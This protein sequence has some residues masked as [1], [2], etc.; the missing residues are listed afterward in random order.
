MASIVHDQESIHRLVERNKNNVYRLAMLYC[1]NRADADDIF[2]EVFLRYCKK[3][4][5]FDSQEHEKAWFIRVT[6]NCC[7][8]LL[9]S[10]WFQKTTALEESIPAMT[11]EEQGLY[12][13][14]KELPP[15]YRVVIYLYFY[16]GYSLV[17]VADMMGKNQ[18][19]VRTYLFRAKR[20]LKEVL[21]KEE[22]VWSA[23]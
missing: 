20:Q 16:Q 22:F 14:I 4:P 19:T 13:Y 5:V 12:T 21:E 11:K 6:V 3:Q 10:A 7:K 15:N 1:K 23:E 17:E 8:S 18:N 9:R 2:Q